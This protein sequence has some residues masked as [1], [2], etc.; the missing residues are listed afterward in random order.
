[1]AVYVLIYIFGFG[2]REKGF[3]CG[4]DSKSREQTISQNYLIVRNDSSELQGINPGSAIYLNNF[5]SLEK[6]KKWRRV[7]Y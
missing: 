1:M 7:N 2:G 5:C 3:V 4:G 6:R